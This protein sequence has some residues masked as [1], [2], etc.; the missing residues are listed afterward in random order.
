MQVTLTLLPSE[1][2]KLFERVLAVLRAIG[3]KDAG[4]FNP[5]ALRTAKTL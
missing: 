4:N 3:L 1:Q 2:P 5:I